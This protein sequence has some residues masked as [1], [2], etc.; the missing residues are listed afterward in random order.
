MRR[1]SAHSPRCYLFTIVYDIPPAAHAIF[2]LVRVRAIDYFMTAAFP[3]ST[4]VPV[5]LPLI[6]ST[7]LPPTPAHHPRTRR[8]GNADCLL[9]TGRRLPIAGCH[10][11]SLLPACR[12]DALL[13][14]AISLPAGARHYDNLAR[15]ADRRTLP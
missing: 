11:A 8:I 10:I 14:V 13:S 6:Q 5:T 15:R 4:G 1:P 3:I 2:I 9:A 7:P 12:S